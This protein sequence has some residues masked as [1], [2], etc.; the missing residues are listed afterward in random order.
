MT[1]T[2]PDH[3][4]AHGEAHGGHVNHNLTGFIIFLCSESVIFLAFFS[5]YYGGWFDTLTRSTVDILRTGPP[6]VIL[7]IIAIS[8]GSL[9]SIFLAYKYIY[10]IFKNSNC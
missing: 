10:D 4:A 6:L 2:N 5:G 7:I 3:L 8:I 9:V 1:T